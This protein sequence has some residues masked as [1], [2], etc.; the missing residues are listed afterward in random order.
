MKIKWIKKEENTIDE[1]RNWI[2]WLSNRQPWKAN[3]WSGRKT[4]RKSLNIEI[5]S[6]NRKYER[7]VEIE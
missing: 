3:E 4:Q 5:K 6:K 1:M 2:K 7:K